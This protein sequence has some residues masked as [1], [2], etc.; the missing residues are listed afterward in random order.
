MLQYKKDSTASL[1]MTEKEQIQ[2]L[3][4]TQDR[5]DF[6]RSQEQWEMGER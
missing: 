2:R 5:G 1:K 4:E 3:S 6:T